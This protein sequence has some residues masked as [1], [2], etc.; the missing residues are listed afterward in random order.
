MIE[1]KCTECRYLT[2]CYYA[3]L[4]ADGIGCNFEDFCEFQKPRIVKYLSGILDDCDLS[5]ED[6]VEVEKTTN[7][8]KQFYTESDLKAAAERMKERC[9]EVAEKDMDYFTPAYTDVQLGRQIEAQAIIRK[10][11]ALEVEG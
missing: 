2:D 11:K 6:W 5:T 8:E 1:R 9:I 3:F 10:I 7:R 4:R